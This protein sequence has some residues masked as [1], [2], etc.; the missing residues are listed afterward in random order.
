MDTPQPISILRQGGQA[1]RLS[2]EGGSR[3]ERSH[4]IMPQVVQVK[5]GA[6]NNNTFLALAGDWKGRVNLQEFP[7][8]ADFTEAVREGAGEGEGRHVQRWGDI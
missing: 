2:W 4:Q 7:W 5:N 6:N 3:E 8:T 1:S